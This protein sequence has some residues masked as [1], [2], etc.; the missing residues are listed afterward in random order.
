MQ[1]IASKWSNMSPR[2]LAIVRIIAALIFMTAGTMKLFGIPAMTGFSTVPLFSQMGLAG[3]LE[4]F[5]G[6]L[7]V[8]GLFARPVAFIL[9]IEMVIAYFQVHAPQGFW[10]TLNMGQ[11]AILYAL[12]WLYISSTGA[13]AWSLD[14]WRKSRKQNS[15]TTL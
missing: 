14:V 13:G 12:L 4:T 5:G 9:F 7:L 11:P 1:N 3:V 2:I 10:P 6:L 15:T 8:L